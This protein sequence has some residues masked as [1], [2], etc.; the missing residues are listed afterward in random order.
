MFVRLIPTNVADSLAV[1]FGTNTDSLEPFWFVSQINIHENPKLVMSNK[2]IEV[3]VAF[4]SRDAVAN[5]D[6]LSLNLQEHDVVHK[7]STLLITSS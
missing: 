4:R 6:L 7:H 5:V 2:L 1:G 3:Q